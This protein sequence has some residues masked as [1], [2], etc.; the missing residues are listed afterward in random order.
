[1]TYFSDNFKK[2]HV[3]NLRE[4]Q[5]QSNFISLDKVIPSKLLIELASLSSL[6]FKIEMKSKYQTLA[7][8]LPLKNLNEIKAKFFNDSNKSENLDSKILEI[9]PIE[10][11]YIILKCSIVNKNL[12]LVPPIRIFVPYN[13]PKNNP[14]VDLLQLDDFDDEMLPEYSIKG[15]FE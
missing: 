5:N 12:V 10:K 14:F 11:D 3:I 4:N 6:N 13:Y 8:P 2:K 1:M 15:Y 7:F 9:S